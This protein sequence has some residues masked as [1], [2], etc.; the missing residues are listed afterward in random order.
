M[1]ETKEG[2]IQEGRLDLKRYEWS[3]AIRNKADHAPVF[4]GE[5]YQEYRNVALPPLP[6]NGIDEEIGSAGVGGCLLAPKLLLSI[7]PSF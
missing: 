4:N 5:S 6:H 2:A 3:S 1:R 7:A